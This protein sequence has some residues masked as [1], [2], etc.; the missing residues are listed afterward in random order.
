MHSGT[1][2]TSKNGY[3]CKCR[4]GYRGNQCEIGKISS[5]VS[6]Y[7]FILYYFLLYILHSISCDL[8]VIY[9][10]LVDGSWAPWQPFTRCNAACLKTRKRICNQPAPSTIGGAKCTGGN[11]LV[12]NQRLKCNP[13]FCG[14]P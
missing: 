11:G 9:F 5:L 7:C 1:C 6:F 3:T 10:V 2:S 12:Q 4:T 8:I 14:K 13:R